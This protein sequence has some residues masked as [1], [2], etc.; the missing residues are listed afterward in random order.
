MSSFFIALAVPLVLALLGVAVN[1]KARRYGDVYVVEYGRSFRAFTWIFV[2]LAVAA[3]A[4]CR[5]AGR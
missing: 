1:P 5:R 4:C 3:V 2:L